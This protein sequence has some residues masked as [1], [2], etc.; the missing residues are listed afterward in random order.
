M[1]NR[2]FDITVKTANVI[3]SKR[4]IKTHGQPCHFHVCNVFIRWMA[5]RS[6]YDARFQEA[7]A[8]S[9]ACVVDGS[10]Q[11]ASSLPDHAD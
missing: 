8:R 1:L 5:A 4:N 11:A 2:G 7:H 9:K 6:N 3:K 10:P